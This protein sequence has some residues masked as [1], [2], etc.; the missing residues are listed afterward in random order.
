MSP[1]P[2]R[3]QSVWLPALPDRCSITAF[4][5]SPRR[6]SR[7]RPEDVRGRIG[8]REQTLDEVDGV[9]AEIITDTCGFD[10]AR[11]GVVGLTKERAKSNGT[12]GRG[13]HGG[14]QDCTTR[15]APPAS[16][17]DRAAGLMGSH[18]R[19]PVGL[20]GY[21]QAPAARS[22]AA[23]SAWFCSMAMAS[24]VFPRSSRG[25]TSAPRASKRVTFSVL[26]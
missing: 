3:P 25:V 10:D 19:P 5:A 7:P 21:S 6:H 23:T 13:G 1:V 9:K 12:D 11:P 24:A 18:P 15:A 17:L 26:P 4:S 16:R 2:A 22:R 8:N 14:P 20:D